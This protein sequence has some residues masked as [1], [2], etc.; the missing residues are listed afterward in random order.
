MILVDANIM[1]MDSYRQ[2]FKASLDQQTIT[3]LRQCLQT[4]TPLGNDRFRE[5][6]E[7]TLQVKVGQSKRGRPRIPAANSGS[8]PG[9]SQ[10]AARE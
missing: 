3:S 1:M 8:A 10:C 5:Q 7:A 6:I 4:G 2:L 9:G